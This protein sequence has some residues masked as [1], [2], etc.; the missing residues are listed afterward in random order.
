MA[1]CGEWRYIEV[2]SILRVAAYREWRYVKSGGIL[3][4]AV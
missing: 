4:V 2:D 3:R 1:V